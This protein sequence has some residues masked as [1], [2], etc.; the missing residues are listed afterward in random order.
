ML[1]DMR[2]L[3]TDCACQMAAPTQKIEN[4]ANGSNDRR[5]NQAA[6]SRNGAVVPMII[7]LTN[8]H[9]DNPR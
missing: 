1:C 9:R 7:T 3:C 4:N 8:E 6:V 5:D 2:R